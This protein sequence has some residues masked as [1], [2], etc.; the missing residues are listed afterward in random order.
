MKI[1]MPNVSRKLLST[2]T[3]DSEGLYVN[4]KYWSCNI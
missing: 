3:E 1:T 2:N 4:V